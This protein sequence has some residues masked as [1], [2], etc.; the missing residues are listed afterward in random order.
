[1]TQRSY[2][3]PRNQARQKHGDGLK[4]VSRK[5]SASAKPAR[6][7]GGSVYTPSSKTKSST[8]DKLNRS[9]NKGGADDK[10]ARKSERNKQRRREMALGSQLNDMPEYKRW[11]R[12]WWVMIVVAVVAVG[13]SLLLGQLRNSIGIDENIMNI[14][15]PVLLIVGY[16]CIIAALF[17]DLGKI[18]KMRKGLESQVSTMSKKELR[19]LDA[20]IEQSDKA[21]EEQQKQKKGRSLFGKKK[22]TDTQEASEE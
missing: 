11:R 16:G 18:R 21:Y 12:I 2:N 19:K 4:G 14:A 6:P 10:A 15:T 17:I 5:S 7:A 9:L 1:M 22:T 20:A 13:V 3:N 8:K